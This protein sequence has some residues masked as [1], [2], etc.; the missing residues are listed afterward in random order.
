M[1]KAI[2]F[3]ALFVFSHHMWDVV[4]DSVSENISKDFANTALFFF[5]VVSTILALNLIRT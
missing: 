1:V 5:S 2:I 3:F 4:C